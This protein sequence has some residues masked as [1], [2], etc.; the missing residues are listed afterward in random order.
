MYNKA[1]FR[2]SNEWV[3]V[4]SQNK[5]FTLGVLQFLKKELNCGGAV[6]YPSMLDLFSSGA[7][8]HYQYVIIQYSEIYKYDL[9]SLLSIDPAEITFRLI[10]IGQG[11]N[12]LV[13]SLFTRFPHSAHI[14]IC[15]GPNELALAFSALSKDS[16]YVSLSAKKVLETQ[17]SLQNKSVVNLTAREQEVLALLCQGHDTESIAAMLHISPRT[18]VRHKANLMQKTSTSTTLQLVTLFLSHDITASDG[19]NYSSPMQNADKF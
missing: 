15:D 5:F 17:C 11:K 9:Y 19:L 2:F 12:D 18:V 16:S 1:I 10:F 4:I 6:V 3:A 14:A 13:S 7:K 8:K